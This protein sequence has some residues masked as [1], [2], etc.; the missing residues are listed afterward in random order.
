LFLKGVLTK[1]RLCERSEAI[2]GSFYVDTFLDCFATLAK[3]AKT[4]KTTDGKD[5]G[6]KETVYYSV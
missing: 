1:T 2:Q 6:I 4:A 5:I 3:T